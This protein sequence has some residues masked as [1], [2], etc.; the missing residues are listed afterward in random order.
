MATDAF[1]P[2][3]HGSD[4]SQKPEAASA[5]EWLQG[6]SSLVRE[7]LVEVLGCFIGILFTIAVCALVI[8]S[9]SCCLHAFCPAT[10]NEPTFG[11][12]LR[13]NV[14]T[15]HA[16]LLFIVAYV[17]G[18]IFQRQDPKRPDR[19]SLERILRDLPAADLE[20]YEVQTK[21]PNHDSYL[22]KIRLHFLRLLDRF[23][24]RPH[25]AL[26]RVSAAQIA[27]SSGAQFPYSHF[28]KYLQS[29]KLDHLVYLAKWDPEE[30][31]SG[32]SKMF[33]NALKIRIQLVAPKKCGEIVR[34]EAHVRMMSS[35]W[36]AAKAIYGV[37]W[38]STIPVLIA[39][40]R[41]AWDPTNTVSKTS[42]SG[43]IF[44]HDVVVYAAMGSFALAS[45]LWLKWHVE[46]RFHYQRV[47]EVV[48]VF[49]TV[50]CLR[51]SKFPRILEDLVP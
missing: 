15:F 48:Y 23:F 12:L 13:S 4:D 40:W 51:R 50:E 5:T 24:P 42:F 22:W 2:E 6:T 25:Q 9:G 14:D 30:N 1:F 35:V 32:C 16:W 44:S 21:A 39:L 7:F 18:G 43:A 45:A 31:W 33:I 34:N 19:K 10:G 17:V 20:H 11:V 26:G 37:F 36:F 29:R 3:A 49:E 46:S 8:T 47:K 38:A 28:K 27:V 41:L